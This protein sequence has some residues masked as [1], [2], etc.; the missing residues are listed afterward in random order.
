MGDV[1]FARPSESQT[2]V[3]TTQREQEPDPCAKAKRKDFCGGYVQTCHADAQAGKSTFT[4]EAENGVRIVANSLQQC[5]GYAGWMADFHGKPKGVRVPQNGQV[6]PPP[7]P[8]SSPKPKAPLAPPKKSPVLLAPPNRP[9]GD[10]IQFPGKRW[11]KELSCT[12]D[13]ICTITVFEYG[14]FQK[15]YTFP[16]REIADLFFR[17]RPKIRQAKNETERNYLTKLRNMKVLYHF[18]KLEKKELNVEDYK[19]KY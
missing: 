1:K 2:K 7:P 17:F 8:A 16:S 13:H 18:D 9:Q 12:R 10:R 15:P 19:K 14:R 3:T 11:V 4:L 6:A 5:L